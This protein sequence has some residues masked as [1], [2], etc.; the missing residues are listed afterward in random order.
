MH[1]HALAPRSAS[2]SNYISFKPWSGGFNN[3]RMSLEIAAALA[4]A[5]NRTLVLPPTGG[6]I[7]LRGK[8][9]LSNYF[10]LAELS[11]IVRV[12]S[13]DKFSGEIGLTQNNGNGDLRAME[14]DDAGLNISVRIFDKKQ[15]MQRII[16]VPRCP[17]ERSPLFHT[18]S[19]FRGRKTQLD[20]AG[21]DL[22]SIR[23]LH[24]R[25][26]LL[27]NFYNILWTEDV[28]LGAALKRFV[29]DHIH[30]HE[31]IF[32]KAERIV[33][34]LGGHF[35]FSCLHVRR[36]D[37]QYKRVLIPAAKILANTR[38]I[39]APNEMLYVS[40][41]ERSN[42]QIS[43]D[44]AATVKSANHSWFAPLRAQY[45]TR[46]LSDYHHLLRNDTPPKLF[47]CVEQLVCSRGRV[48]VGTYFSTFTSY[49]HR[50]RGYMGD[51]RHKSFLYS[52][53][54][55]PEDYRDS[56]LSGLK[57]VGSLGRDGPSWS[58][59][60]NSQASWARE[61][62]EAWEDTESPIF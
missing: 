39:F 24:F 55:Y 57:A 47:G 13:Y 31:A 54:R 36:N 34:A 26:S 8:S 50:L 5:L 16:C 61:Y 25:R 45:R 41:D 22:A 27:G 14:I 4:Y 3:V 7:Y 18:F 59:I 32:E 38:R 43:F 17:G 20:A 30:Y 37:F 6:R 33:H 58:A 56:S 48:F 28:L 19:K 52:H 40:T 42:D 60:A 2:T 12:I 35:A 51:V 15:V 62:V 9:D 29:R 49:I 46:F 10:D 53:L 44:P 21:D 23:V 11:S 1:P